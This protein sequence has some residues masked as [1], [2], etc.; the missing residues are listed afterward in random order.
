MEML[1]LK[2]EIVNTQTKERFLFELHKTDYCVIEA[3]IQAT[4]LMSTDIAPR[5]SSF[6]GYEV[7]LSILLIHQNRC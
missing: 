7:L 1:L 2:V 4:C 5:L 6:T 3:T